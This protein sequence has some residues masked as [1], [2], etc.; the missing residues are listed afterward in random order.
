M[1]F[2]K[3]NRVQIRY[4]KIVV[5]LP[6]AFLLGLTYWLYVDFNLHK[7]PKS[8]VQTQLRIYGIYQTLYIMKLDTKEFPTTGQGLI[9]LI[10]NSC[11]NKYWDGP[12]LTNRSLKDYWHQALIFIHDQRTRH[13]SVYSIGENGIDE[14]G[15]GDDITCS[16]LCDSQLKEFGFSADELTATGFYYRADEV[17][18]DS[19]VYD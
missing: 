15:L 8:L 2:R 1:L 3:V 18:K 4:M 7:T 16:G 10:N 17:S 5:F 9:C 13:L 6:V 19:E 11:G 12:Y 14:D